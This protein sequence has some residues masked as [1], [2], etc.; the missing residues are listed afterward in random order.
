MKC[1]KCESIVSIS[2]VSCKKCGEPLLT[3]QQ[4]YSKNP[5]YRSRFILFFIAWIG[6]FCG[7]HLEYLG[8]HDDAMRMKQE[9]NI[10]KVFSLTPK[11]W[12]VLIKILIIQITIPVMILLGMYRVDANG[13]LVRYFKPLRNER[14]TC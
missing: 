11:G 12:I 5:P 3:V 10:R 14:S 1:K 8:F 13:Y 7:K 9:N 6:A 2:D 4:E